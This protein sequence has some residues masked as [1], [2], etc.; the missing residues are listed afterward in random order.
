MPDFFTLDF[1]YTDEALLEEED[2]IREA[3]GKAQS[4]LESRTGP[5]NEFLGWLEVSSLLTADLLAEIEEAAGLI[6][7]R[8]ALLVIGVGGSY[9]GTRAVLTALQAPFKKPSLPLYFAGHHLDASYHKELLDFLANRTYAINVI[10]KS[11]TTSEPALAF[12]L[13]WEHL[14]RNFS[15][16]ELGDLVFVTTDAKKGSLRE[17]V[18]K[19]ELTSFEIPEDVGGRY[20]VFTPVAFLPLAAAGISISK[21]IEGASRMRAQLKS[22]DYRSNPALQYAVYRNKA[23]RAGKKIEILAAYQQNLFYLCEWWKQLFG[24][25][26]GKTKTCIFPTSLTFTTDLHS[27]GQWVQQGERNIFETVLDIENV[28]GPRIP[29]VK[30]HTDGLDYLEGKTLH[31]INQSATEATLMAHKEGQVPCLRIRIPKLNEESL[32]ALLYFFE[33][34]CALSAYA[35]GLNPFDQPGVEAYKKN[36]SDL[37]ARL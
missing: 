9:L 3:V 17:F 33:Y 1:R 15:V 36:M 6:Q 26:E 25:S 23:Y 24:E 30:D 4:L 28:E 34:S 20:S 14:R 7:K 21:L 35:F 10:S 11:G 16:Q 31:S 2:E 29:G 27:L 12:R 22:A 5:G 37:L 18:A 8:E 19:H 32:G 13:F